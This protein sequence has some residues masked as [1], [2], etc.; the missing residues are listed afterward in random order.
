MDPRIPYS[1]GSALLALC[2]PSD[3]SLE[4]LA[5]DLIIFRIGRSQSLAV[6]FTLNSDGKISRPSSDILLHGKPRTKN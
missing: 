2:S 3:G 5:L 6:W 1:I 4:S